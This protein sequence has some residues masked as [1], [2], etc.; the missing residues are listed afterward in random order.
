M[1]RKH[2]KL[3]V[4]QLADSLAGQVY[5]HSASFPASERFGLQSQLRRAAV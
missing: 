3:R 4:F 1:S 2:D 5:R